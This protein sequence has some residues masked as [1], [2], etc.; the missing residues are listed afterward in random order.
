MT[1]DELSEEM[2]E[3]YS[4]VGEELTVSLDRET[5]NELAMLET[6]LEP[7]ETDELVRRAIHM[8]F[9]STV[10]TGTMDFHLR[11]GF[12]VTYDEYLSGMTFDEMTGANQYPT[13]DDE[14]RYQF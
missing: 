1:L 10:E 4:D 6:A 13:M 5:R 12:D 2:Q 11:S 8:L 9:Q 3:S 7:E 14:R